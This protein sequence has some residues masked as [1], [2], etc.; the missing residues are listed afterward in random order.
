VQAA[1][2][3]LVQSGRLALEE[4]LV[5]TPEFRPQ[6][7]GGEIVLRRLVGRI[8]SAG[9]TPP[10]LKE[11][12]AAFKRPDVAEFLRLAA[13]EG[14]LWAVERDRYYGRTAL[15]QFRRA[16]AEIGARGDITPGALR[17]RLGL[18]RKYLIPLLEWSDAER[19]TFRRGDVRRL[20]A[21]SG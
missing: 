21:P 17:E 18:S 4:G 12:E 2:T 1:L 9:L 6:V 13:R 19:L 8:E 20:T 15:D 11:L 3:E 14:R 10:N 16:L 5:R 7:V